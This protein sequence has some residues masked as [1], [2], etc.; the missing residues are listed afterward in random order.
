MEAYF[1]LILFRFRSFR[2]VAGKGKSRNKKEEKLR[3]PRSRSSLFLNTVR[4]MVCA[5]RAG[6][7]AGAWDSISYRRRSYKLLAA[8]FHNRG[9]RCRGGGGCRAP[10]CTSVFA[11]AMKGEAR[12]RGV[13]GWKA[14]PTAINK[15]PPLA[16]EFGGAEVSRLG[17]ATRTEHFQKA[18]SVSWWRRGGGDGS[19]SGSGDIGVECTWGWM[20]SAKAYRSL[21]FSLFALRS[22]LLRELSSK[23]PWPLELRRRLHS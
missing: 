16:V 9:G 13:K 8:E 20:D 22:S 18:V 10:G 19:G 14:W 6:A 12:R 11:L 21:R 15:P 1:I 2:K 23:V 17:V 7:S 4:E 5:W 3:F